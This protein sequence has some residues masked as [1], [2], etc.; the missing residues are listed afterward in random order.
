MN[1]KFTIAQKTDGKLLLRSGGRTLEVCGVSEA[2]RLMKRTRRQ[3][4]RRIEAGGLRPAAKF[5]G[6]WLLETSEVKRLALTPPAVQP[7]PGKLE[8]L[9][10]EYELS[11]LNA[12]TDKTL[13]ISR[14]LERGGMEEVNWA[15]RRYGRKTLSGFIREDGARLLGRRSLGLWS[16]VLKTKADPAP[17]WRAGGPW[18]D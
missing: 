3:I 1:I 18:R 6:E 9:F 12:G 5:L 10:P 15:F 7:L 13:I 11:K 14:I 4:Y 16:L 8:R 2:A 17:P